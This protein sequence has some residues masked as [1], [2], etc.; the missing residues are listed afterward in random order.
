MRN[1][2]NNDHKEF[3]LKI[4][5]NLFKHYDILALIGDRPEDID[6]S[7]QF[8]IPALILRTTIPDHEI[9]KYSSTDL[10]GGTFCQ[11]WIEVDSHLEVLIEGRK[12]LERLREE[13][14][15]QYA[16]WL[17]D[18]DNKCRITATISSIITALAGKIFLDGL[19]HPEQEKTNYILI[20]VFIFSV[21]SLLFSIRSFTSR[22]TSGS[23]TG[24]TITAKLKQWISILLGFLLSFPPQ[25]V[26]LLLT[27][28]RSFLSKCFSLL[29]ISF[30]YHATT[31]FFR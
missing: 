6:V 10:N 27:F 30:F 9:L 29:A 21:L 4:I 15:N 18:L 17:S 20:I 14:S 2:D 5:H 3:K 12:K 8:S 26:L 1:T 23:K 16:K 31:K 19:Q 13:F 25:D 11:S 7:A 24:N 28:F 22:H